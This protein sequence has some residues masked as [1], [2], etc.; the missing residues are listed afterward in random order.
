MIVTRRDLRPAAA[1]PAN[2]ELIEPDI[3]AI[4]GA[5]ALSGLPCRCELA[6]LA[7]VLL[8]KERPTTRVSV[9]EAPDEVPREDST[10]GACSFGSYGVAP[11][12]A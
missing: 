12:F 4:N 5:P 1:C 7:V 2:G 6:L 3:S 11:S 10:P 9:G 8:G